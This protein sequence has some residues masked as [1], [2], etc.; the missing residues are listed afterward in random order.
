MIEEGKMNENLKK[1]LT[2]VYSNKGNL[3]SIAKE[4]FCSD[5][6]DNSSTSDIL[7]FLDEGE[8]T[9]SFKNFISFLK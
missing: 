2:S 4:I 6:K 9:S 5:I 1:I 3:E 8:Y 7:A